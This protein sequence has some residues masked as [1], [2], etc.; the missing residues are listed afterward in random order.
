MSELVT[1]LEGIPL[2][3]ELAAAR[4]RTLSVL[5]INRRLKDRYK[6][7]IGGSRVLQQRQQT[8]R[9]LVDW[10]YDLLHDSEKT[11]LNRLAPFKGGF[12]MEAA[13]AVCSDELLPADDVL[14]LLSSL[15][16]KSLL[17]QSESNNLSDSTRYRMLETIRE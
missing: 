11:L 10:S 9:A 4:V 14:D 12:D 5:D 15:V 6:I 17:M 2:A 8:L 3:L 7:L 13:E 1:R 16:E